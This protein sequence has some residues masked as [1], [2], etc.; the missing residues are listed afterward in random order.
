MK[1]P[2][3]LQGRLAVGLSLAVTSLWLV[4]T[5]ASGLVIRQEFNELSDSAL[6]ETAQ[7]LLPLALAE[8]TD[9]MEDRK[10][11]FLARV[12]Q[13]EEFL[14]YLVRDTSGNILLS[15]HDAD[16]RNFP[17][18][19]HLGF[20]ETETHRIYA[21]ATLRETIA[22]EVA[23]PLWH[24]R[25]ATWEAVGTLL[26]PLA[27]LIPLS[28]AAVWWLVRSALQ[29]LRTFTAEIRTRGEADLSPL[30]VHPLPTE[31]GPVADALNRLLERLRWVRDAEKR[32]SANSAHELRTPLA[33]TLAQ[34]QRLLAEAPDGP[35][36][37]RAQR[38]E[39]SLHQL[40]RTSEKLMQLATA[41]G[42]SL[43]CNSPHDL[44]PVLVQVVEELRGSPEEARTRINLKL[45]ESPV[46]SHLDPDAFGILM[47]NLIENALKHS[48][49]GTPV[50]V[51]IHNGT[52]HV[53]NEGSVVAPE[54]LRELGK[55]FVRGSTRASGSG[56]GLAIAEAIAAGSGCSLVVTSPARGRDDGF[57]VEVRLPTIASALVGQEAA[58]A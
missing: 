14:T 48:P 53:V 23:E 38:I 45:T 34:A 16:P 36:R 10:T 51:V 13:H 46:R 4:A 3:S 21:E 43:L 22:I 47:R 25:E 39:S 18:R 41:E 29:P 52:V 49:A 32:F 11:G 42:G 17:A 7:R 44:A 58:G 35:L 27:A 15:S 40:S 31:I 9:R 19:P 20:Q 50:D 30:S 28:L 1:R 57:E 2:L 54:V 6:Q 37:H 33:A 5:I 55:P 26:L 24:R 12:S 8:I 56:L